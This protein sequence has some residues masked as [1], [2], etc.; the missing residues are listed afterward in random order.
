[1]GFS[2]DAVW[3]P[4]DTQDVAVLGD[5]LELFCWITP[6]PDDLTLLI[7]DTTNKSEQSPSGTSAHRNQCE[8]K[9]ENQQQITDCYS[10][11]ISSLSY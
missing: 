7:T 6:V 8:C 5:H 3:D 10:H 2:Q 9:M 1:M 11:G 4:V